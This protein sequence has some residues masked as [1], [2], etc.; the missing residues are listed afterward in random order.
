MAFSSCWGCLLA[1][2]FLTCKT[3]AD[4]LDGNDGVDRSGND[5]PNMP[6]SLKE[7]SK[8]RDCAS[9]CSNNPECQAWVFSKPNCGGSGNQC[10]FKAAVPKQVQDS[11]K[12]S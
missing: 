3:R 4:W 9:M 6:I 12:V 2:L 5:L 8:P 1:L 7:G 10:W 11:C